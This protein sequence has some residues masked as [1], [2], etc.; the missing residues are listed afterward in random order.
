M[1]GVLRQNNPRAEMF[2]VYLL[3]PSLQ[4]IESPG[5]VVSP[6]APVTGMISSTTTPAAAS[7]ATTT[8]IADDGQLCQAG[9]GGIDAGGN[10][11]M[12]MIGVVGTHRT[13]P[14]AELGYIFHPS[15]WGK[16]YATEAVSAFVDRFWPAQ[17]AANEIEA[18]V[19]QANAASAHVLRKCGFDLVA[20]RDEDGERLLIFRTFR[21]AGG[22]RGVI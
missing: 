3:P 17:V 7:T 12:A 6:P 22:E 13:D 9:N 5:N 8:I 15:A 14:I 19:D 18:Q 2:A 10:P 1:S 20:E 16:G 21:P 11:P 4:P